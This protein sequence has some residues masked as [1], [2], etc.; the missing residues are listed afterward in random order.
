MIIILGHVFPLLVTSGAT[1]CFLGAVWPLAPVCFR[2][3]C[4]R[5]LRVCFLSPT[6]TSGPEHPHLQV[7][8]LPEASRVRGRQAEA[9]HPLLPR[10]LLQP[11]SVH[12]DMVTV[13]WVPL[14]LLWSSG[15][16]RR[17]TGPITRACAGP[18]WRAW[19]CPSWSA[20]RSPGSL[21]PGSPSCWKVTPGTLRPRHRL[22]WIYIYI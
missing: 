3:C 17:A 22:E 2:R 7:R 20:C 15:R 12:T 19:A 14:T 4:S 9:L 6:E 21:T 18:S 16:V 8:R 11:V 5:L 13:L 1:W 10:G